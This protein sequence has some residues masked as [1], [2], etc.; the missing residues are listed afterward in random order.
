MK[1]P[2]ELLFVQAPSKGPDPS[3]FVQ[4]KFSILFLKEEPTHYI[5]IRPLIASGHL[6]I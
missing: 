4:L 6:V 1:L 5:N 2:L 3:S